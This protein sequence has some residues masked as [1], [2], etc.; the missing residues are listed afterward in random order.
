MPDHESVRRLRA[1][2]QALADGARETSAEAVVRRVF[3]IQAQDA[4]AADLGIRVRGSNITA[5]AIRTAYEDERSIVRNWYMRGTLHT[6]PGDDAHWV[7]QLLSPRVLAATGRRYQQLGLGDDLRRRAGQLVRRVLAAHGPLTRAELTERLTTLGIPP[8]GQAPFY[9]IRHAALTGIL[10]HGPQRAGEATYV[11]LDDWLPSTGRFR[12]EGDDALAELARRYLAAHA[13]A[14]L[15]D[16]AAWSGLPVTWARRAWKM[17]AESGVITEYGALTVL[18]GRVKELPGPSDPPDVR[19]L[20]A[21]DNYLIG[22]RT[23]ELSVPALHQARVRP[24]GG[25]IRPTVIVDGLAIATWTRGPGSRSLQVDAFEPVPP[26]FEQGI[27][28]EKE[29]VVGFLRPAP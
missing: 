6:I 25:L 9:L 17:L 10:C 22:Y 5:Q 23:R 20:P 13:P 2:A 14:T 26:R 3:A 8:D 28:V 4:T 27:D 15:E 1:C 12:R 11:L 16:F 24:G 18:A 19:M 29:A 7:L 21:Y